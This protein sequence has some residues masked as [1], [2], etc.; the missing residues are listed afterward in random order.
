MH[1]LQLKKPLTEDYWV[2]PRPFLG[3]GTGRGGKKSCFQTLHAVGILRMTWSL[4]QGL[5]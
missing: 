2:C 1:C 5:K 3:L 4:K